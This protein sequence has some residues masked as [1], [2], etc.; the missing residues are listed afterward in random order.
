[1]E[2]SLGQI[3]Y[4]ASDQ[5]FWEENNSEDVK[6]WEK[7]A[8]AVKQEALTRLGNSQHALELNSQIESAH[9]WMDEL[10]GD[11]ET[12]RTLDSL[13]LR[14]EQAA[15]NKPQYID[16]KDCQYV[17]DL[18]KEKDRWE[19]KFHAAMA[20]ASTHLEKVCKIVEEINEEIN[21]NI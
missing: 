16:V 7:V 12:I 4:E 21:D 15:K 2:K 1:M 19:K 3:A 20:L 11:V 5:T 9:L 10:L 13:R 6:Y 8:E 18:K 14:C 17:V